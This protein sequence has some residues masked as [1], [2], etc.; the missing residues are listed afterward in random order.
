MAQRLKLTKTIVERLDFEKEGQWVTDTEVPQLVVRLSRTS[1]RYVARWTS[2]KDSKRR[3]EAIA[4]TSAIS[5][6]EARDRARKL[7]ASD[8]ARAVET[9]SDVYDIWDK[10]HAS[11]AS[12]AHAEEF[13][14][15]WRKHIAP[16]LGHA[17]LS[18]ITNKALQ[19][20][21]DK[22]RQEHPVTPSGQV[23]DTPYSAAAVRR[24]IA[25]IGKLLTI[26]RKQGWMVGNPVEGLEMSTPNRRLDVFT[27]DDVKELS[28][29]LTAQRERFPI[30]V[31]L[32]RFLLLFP[33]RG[34]E[35]RDMRWSDLDLKGGVWTIPAARYKSKRDK[36]F[37]L[38]PLQVQHL[39]SIP[40]RSKT[41]VFPMVTDKD[42]PVAKSHQ[43][44]V[45]E[46]LRP[47]PLGIHTLRKTIA[48][49]LLNKQVPLEV[50]SLILGHSTTLVTQQAYAHL[51]P[52]A[53]R[54]HLE[55][56]AAIL[57]DDE[58]DTEDDIDAVLHA[59]RARAIQEQ[60]A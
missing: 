19:E 42:R 8:S 6:S 55:K 34:I 4:D 45:W 30:G 57:M 13:R 60:S 12:E 35:A 1:K 5:V 39:D 25:Y 10:L 17:K 29:T 11:K 53:A 28:E 54:E 43:R 49:L 37:P 20:W 27:R 41:Y 48:T 15:S 40:R 51:D 50:V 59:Q 32:I 44:Y 7:V 38:G 3:Q 24:W 46:A 23:R 36:T 47:K 2:P 22:K 26:A 31:D 16:D 9:L 56:W 21:Y 58:G 18:R 52:Q 33:C 14:R